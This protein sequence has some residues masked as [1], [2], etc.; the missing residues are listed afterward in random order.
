MAYLGFELD[1]PRPGFISQSGELDIVDP[2][3][4]ARMAELG[5]GV[6]SVPLASIFGLDVSTVWVEVAEDGV[7]I[8]EREPLPAVLSKAAIRP[9]GKDTAIVT[10]LPS[11]SEIN[12]TSSVG[13]QTVTV[14]DGS[15]EITSDVADTFTLTAAVWPYLDWS[16]TVTAK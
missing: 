1:G 14:T 2:S 10:G 8:T 9:N 15:L 16:A 5:R 4:P 12:V 6:I 7:F 13:S 11:P 3:F